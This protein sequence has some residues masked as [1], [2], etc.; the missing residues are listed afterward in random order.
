MKRQGVELHDPE[1]WLYLEK[2]VDTD[3]I[4]AL[5]NEI[6]ER[7]KQRRM[8]ALV[9]YINSRGGDADIAIGFYQWARFLNLNLTTIGCGQLS[10]SA[11]VILLAGTKRYVLGDTY[12]YFHEGTVPT[13]SDMDA[14]ALDQVRARFKN[15]CMVFNKIITAESSLT[16]KELQGFDRKPYLMPPIEAVE[17]G[18]ADRIIDLPRARQPAQRKRTK[19]KSR[20]VVAK[21]R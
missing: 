7:L 12:F 1:Y 14:M 9:L 2:D 4:G 6:T 17:Y 16:L 21:R 8:A 10:S 20:P 15:T 3:S 11:V 13:T 5:K 18:L 19:S